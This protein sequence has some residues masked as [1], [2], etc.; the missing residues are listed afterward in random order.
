MLVARR[1]QGFTLIELLIAVAII[2]ILAAVAYPSYQESVRKSARRTAQSDLTAAA[3]AMERRKAV[4]LSYAGATAG[5]GGTFP[6]RSPDSGTLKY[7]LSIVGTPT[8]TTY[9]LKAASTDAQDGDSGVVEILMINEAGQTCFAR[10]GASTDT[11]AFGSDEA[12]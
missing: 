7:D 1:Y 6:S 10:K 8:A 9:V 4:S 5:S 3:S 2:A 12:W 11:C